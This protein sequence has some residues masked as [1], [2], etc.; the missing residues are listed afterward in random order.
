MQPTI[1]QMQNVFYGY[2]MYELEN[3]RIDSFQ[4]T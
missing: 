4:F 2:F 3:Y 1:Q